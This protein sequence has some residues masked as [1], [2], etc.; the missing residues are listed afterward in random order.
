MFT[1]S[2]PESDEMKWFVWTLLALAVLA[3]ALVAAVVPIAKTRL[4]EYVKRVVEEGG[5]SYAGVPVTLDSADFQV[6]HDVIYLNGLAV[7]NPPGFDSDTAI[8]AGRVLVDIDVR[9]LLRDTVVIRRILVV[10]PD[11]VYELVLGRDN[12]GRILDGVAA[13][14]AEKPAATGDVRKVV[15]EELW[16]KD[17]KL[18]VGIVRGATMPVGMDD[19]H[20][21]NIG[22]GGGGGEGGGKGGVLPA[23][24]TRYVLGEVAGSV[25]RVVSSSLG[26]VGDSARAVGGEVLRAP[27]AVGDAVG[28]GAA[29]AWSGVKG[30]FG[31]GTATNVKHAVPAPAGP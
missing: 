3:A 14:S 8:R 7:G 18:R 26:F 20:L 23:E 16:I 13:R 24:V 29:A 1:V 6:L 12:I 19:I 11:I 9:S 27:K 25:G 10:A 5:T 21:T 28:G 4:D 2:S 31:G 22:G 15:I 30:A 17:P